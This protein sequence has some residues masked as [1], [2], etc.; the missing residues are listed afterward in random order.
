MGYQNLWVVGGIG[1]ISRRGWICEKS[2]SFDVQAVVAYVSSK[3]S[4]DQ[5]PFCPLLTWFYIIW[6]KN[7]F[8]LV[9]TKDLW[10]CNMNAVGDTPIRADITTKIT[11]W[12]GNSAISPRNPTRKCRCTAGRVSTNKG[13]WPLAAILLGWCIFQRVWIV[14]YRKLFD[15]ADQRRLQAPLPAVNCLDLDIGQG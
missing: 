14:N 3:E 2:A 15:K 6:E 9:F 10:H 13:G 11:H 5:I 12:G 7:K 8:A 1:I 4:S